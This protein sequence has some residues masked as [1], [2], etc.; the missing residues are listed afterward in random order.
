MGGRVTKQKWAGH[1][2]VARPAIRRTTGGRDILNDEP[3]GVDGLVAG[4]GRVHLRLGAVGNGRG[5]AVAAGV[6]GVIDAAVL[7]VGEAV[8]I[9][10]RVR[11]AEHVRRD[12]GC[13]SDERGVLDAGVRRRALALVEVLGRRDRRANVGLSRGLLSVATEAEIRRHRDGDEDAED[14]DDDQ[15]LDEGEAAFLTSQARLDLADHSEAPS[16]RGRLDG[17]LADVST[18]RKGGPSLVWGIRS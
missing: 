7:A 9:A 15:E 17:S 18:G 1:P 13:N 12:A 3:S 8:A 5:A 11:C 10:G 2:K 14:D 4:A 16:D 6:P